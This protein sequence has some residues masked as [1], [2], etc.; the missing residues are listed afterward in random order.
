MTQREQKRVLVVDDDLAHRTMLCA[1]LRKEGFLTEEADDGVEAVHLVEKTFFDIILL[2]LKMK[3]MGGLEALERIKQLSPAIPVVLITAYASVRTAVE[4]MKLGLCDYL[5]KPVDIDELM[6][7]IRK[8]LRMDEAAPETIPDLEDR[9]FD[10]SDI[11][12]QEGGLRETLEIVRLV[13]RSDATVLITGESGTGK[14][15]IARAIHRNSHRAARPMI[16]INCAA[17]P[18]NLLESEL[19]GFEKGAFT[20]ADTKKMGKFELASGGTLF[21]DEI[22]DMSPI[23]QAKVLRVLQEGVF[24]R[25]GGTRSL[26]ADVRIIAATN[27][28]LEAEVEKGNFRSDLYFRLSVVPVHLPPLRER[29]ADIPLLVDHFL[30]KYVR[31]NNRLIRGF[32]PEAM[33]LLSR[34]TWPGNVRELENLVE[35]AVLLSRTT[36]IGVDSLPLSL[37]RLPRDGAQPDDDASVPVRPIREVE[38]ELILRTLEHTGHNITRAAKL[39]GI[40][41]RGLQYKL[42]SMGID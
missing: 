8:A 15:R 17:L 33:D 10:F 3:Q 38:R 28:N 16:P 39:L 5:M 19:F 9:E 4:G 11:V 40:T 6:A 34:Y 7:V 30:K 41:R 13:A 18:E 27:K 21:L 2:D 35:R 14:E 29:R 1:A 22:G 23:T 36:L 25:L 12:G 31:K 20:G 37:K 42:K 24:E 32:S 26:Q